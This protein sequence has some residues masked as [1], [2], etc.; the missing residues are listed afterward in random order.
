MQEL[1]ENGPPGKFERLSEHFT[2]TKLL[3]TGPFYH[4][5]G[6]NSVNYFNSVKNQVFTEP[7]SILKQRELIP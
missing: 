5:H 1:F 7:I 2:V 3:Q 4:N 6:E